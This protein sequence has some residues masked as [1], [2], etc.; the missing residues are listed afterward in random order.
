MRRDP[1]ESYRQLAPVRIGHQFGSVHLRRDAVESYRV[2]GQLA[3][4]RIGAHA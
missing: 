3:P 4:V 2:S 1:V